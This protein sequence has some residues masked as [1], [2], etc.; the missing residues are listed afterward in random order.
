MR[1]GIDPQFRSK[2]GFTLTPGF[3]LRSKIELIDKGEWVEKEKLHW[4]QSFNIP[5]ADGHPPGFPANTLKVSIQTILGYK[6]ILRQVQ[7]ALTAVTILHPGRLAD[8]IAAIYHASFVAQKE[9][10]TPESLMPILQKIFGEEET[11]E[12]LIKVSIKMK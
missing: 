10:H 3:V 11:K 5:L 6:L 7:R 2:V 12:I 4:A 1:Q 9:V 8:T